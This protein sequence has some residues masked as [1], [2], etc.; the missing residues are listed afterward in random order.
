MGWRLCCNKRLKDQ[1]KVNVSVWVAQTRSNRSILL[2]G[3]YFCHKLHDLTLF[4]ID[5]FFVMAKSICLSIPQSE[6]YQQL[7]ACVVM[8]FNGDVRGS[9]R[10]NPALFGSVLNASLYYYFS[11]RRIKTNGGYLRLGET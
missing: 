10:I 2:A 6:I 3:I 9:Q 11:P 8:T 4:I 1:T 5:V 7:F